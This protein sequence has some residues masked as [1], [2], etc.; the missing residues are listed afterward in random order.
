MMKNDHPHPI[1]KTIREI[2]AGLADMAWPNLCLLC[3]RPLMQG[4]QHV[5]LNCLY[6]LPALYETSFREN[7]TADRFLGKI[8]FERAASGFRYCKDSNIQKALELLKYKGEKEIGSCLS[9]VSS[10]QLIEQGFFKG[11]DALIPVPLHNRKQKKRGYNQ[12]EWIA[13]GI[14]EI[15]GIAVN[16]EILG[17]SV[18]NSSQTTRNLWSRWENAQGLFELKNGNDFC[19]K[20][21]LLVDD[22]LTSGSTLEACGQVLLQIP[23]VR[24]SFFAL[25]LA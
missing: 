17:R 22:V 7:N 4:E 6:E 24:I 23:N 11:I 8:E 9:K 5:C 19:G 10:V 16:T 3:E 2:I 25:A 14:S 12:S 18:H 20:H 15:S 13:K 1:Y 21:L